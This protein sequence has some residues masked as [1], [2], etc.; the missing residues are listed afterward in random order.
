MTKYNKYK[1]TLLSKG[2]NVYLRRNIEQLGIEI[3][4][5]KQIENTLKD[6]YDNT[7]SE[8]E[9]ELMDEVPSLA[10]ITGNDGYKAVD[11]KYVGNM[12]EGYCY[13]YDTRI[14]VGDVIMLYRDDNAHKRFKLMSPE[15]GIGL[16]LEIVKR[17]KLVSLLD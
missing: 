13:T 7:G 4:V 6:V 2:F 1:E 14:K 3:Y 9:M 8:V 10:L 12:K 15:G 16:E 17:F 11:S 5:Y